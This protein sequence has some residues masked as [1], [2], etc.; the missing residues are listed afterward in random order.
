[1]KRRAQKALS[2][3]S[4]KNTSC[5][6]HCTNTIVDLTESFF[7][8]SNESPNAKSYIGADG[9]RTVPFWETDSDTILDPCQVEVVEVR[10]QSD[11]Y[12]G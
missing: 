1:M 4:T 7:V 3:A 8:K 6:G 2:E 10:L 12:P 11:N 5:F 9:F